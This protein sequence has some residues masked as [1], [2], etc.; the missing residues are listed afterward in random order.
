MCLIRDFKVHPFNEWSDHAL[1]SINT[2]CVNQDDEIK[3]DN[4]MTNVN[5]NAG[6][7]DEFRRRII[8]Q[9]PILNRVDS[10][11]NSRE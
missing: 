3:G 6:F 10:D 2:I 1:L 4:G 11:L 8:C 9:L 5:W 7:K